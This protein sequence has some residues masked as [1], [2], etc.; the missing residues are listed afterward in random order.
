MTVYSPADV[1]LVHFPFTDLSS[2]K[3]RPAIILSSDSYTQRFGDY[4]LLA[5]TS[6]AQP[7]EE[8]L[9]S[10]WKEVGLVKETWIKSIMFTISEDLIT[11]KL[12]TLSG[13]DILK[14]VVT[15]KQMIAESFLI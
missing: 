2:H 6:K 4:V 5:L 3:K 13:E 9:L 11:G 10:G 15:I 1:V 8:M 14:V 7:D 12:G